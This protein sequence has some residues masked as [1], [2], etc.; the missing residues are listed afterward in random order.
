MTAASTATDRPASLRVVEHRLATTP[1][2]SGA[3]VSPR[4]SDTDELFERLSE[5]RE[6]AEDV[7]VRTDEADG[8]VELELDGTAVEL[9]ADEARSFADDLEADAREDGWYHAG[10]TKPLLE[11]IEESAARV[12]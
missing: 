3:V 6:N 9:T 1:N 2:V 8:T 10:Q 11:E 7:S 12:A 4:M 5:G